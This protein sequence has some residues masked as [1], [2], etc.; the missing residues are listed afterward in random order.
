MSAL[1][2]MAHHESLIMQTELKFTQPEYRP[3][4]TIQQKFEAFDKANPSVYKR[5]CELARQLVKKGHKQFGIQILWQQL[6]WLI[7][8]EANDP[9]S[10]FR[11]D[12]HYT[13]RFAR[14]MM[15]NEPDLKGIFETRKIVTP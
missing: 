9:N 1:R 11:L 12:D 4:M 5:L 7:Y 8:I 14:K 13:S 15:E 6:R 10:V 3:G 2:R